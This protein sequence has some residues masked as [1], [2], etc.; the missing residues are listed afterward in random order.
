MNII[1][2]KIGLVSPHH[3]PNCGSM[4]QAY[5]LAK[6]IEL[7]GCNAEYISYNTFINKSILQKILFYAVNPGRIANRLKEIL[8]RNTID[9][10][11]FFHDP[12]FAATIQEYEDFYSKYIPH[13]SIIYNPDTIKYI[14]GYWKYIV[15][16]DQTWSPMAYNSK[17]INFLDFVKDNSLKNSYAPSLGTTIVPEEYQKFLKKNLSVFNNLSCREE[18]NCRMI[19]NLTGKNVTHVLDPTLLLTPVQWDEI[20]KDVQIPE[21]YIL[22]YILGERKCISEFAKMLGQEKNIPVYYIVTRPVYLQKENCLTRIGPSQFLSLMRSAAYV[23]TDS[24]H[25]AI[26]SINYNRNFYCFTKRGETIGSNDNCRVKEV[27]KDFGLNERLKEYGDMS[28]LD[29]IIFDEIN[30]L[31]I[32]KRFESMSYLKKIVLNQ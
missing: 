2:K 28:L 10:Y 18:T 27:L 3:D 5:A 24:F 16:S 25:G 7:I 1:D 13:T 31:L 22:C 15:G 9:D 8:K 30:K 4:L 12:A 32:D 14:N 19:S 6:A 29:D 20:S 11:S 17:S 23:V 21:K 26:F